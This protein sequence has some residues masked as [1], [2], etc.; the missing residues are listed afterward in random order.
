MSDRA[1]RDLL[2]VRPLAE[3]GHA[4][5]AAL[6]VWLAA[7]HLPASQLIVW[8]TVVLS[9]QVG[10]LILR[11]S[12][13]GRGA[14]GPTAL[15]PL[16]VSV[17]LLGLAWGG[18][19]WPLWS[20]L[21][22]DHFALTILM[23]CMLAG[24]W[25]LVFAADT[26]SVYLFTIPLLLPIAP[27]VLVHG[28]DDEHVAI[29]AMVLAYAGVTLAF[30]RRLHQ[31]LADRRRAEAALRDTEDQFQRFFEESPI[32][33]SITAPDGKLLRVNRA[34]GALFGY[35]VEELQL[36]SWVDLTH[37]DDL[38][39][40]H[41][42]VRALVAREADTRAMEARYRAK[43]G[44]W[45]WARL[46]M[47][48]HRGRDGQVL[49]FLTH[50]EDISDRKAAADRLSERD[51]QLGAAQAIAHV[52][53]WEWDIPTDRVTW[54][55]ELYRLHG[56]PPTSAASYRAFVAIVDPEDRER[57]ERVIAEGL[58][59]RRTVEYE[60]RIVRPDGVV[61]H[62]LGTNVVVLDRAGAP[63]GLTGT[64]L[65]ITDR[66]RADQALADSERYHRALIDQALDIITIIDADAVMRY[67]SPSVERVLGYRPEE[68]VGQRAFELIH[69][70][71]LEA[72]LKIFMEGVATPGALRTLEYRFRHKDG[73]W[74]HLE[75]V[76]RNL[77]DDPLIH[78]VVVN[79]RDA[80]ERK[81]ATE[82]LADRER[83]YRALIEQALDITTVVDADAFI[84][85]ASPSNER[86][87]GYT[88]AELVGQ[89]VFDFV[90]P[91]DLDTALSVFT[92]G[93]TA[94]GAI[95][96][97]E[98]RFRHRDGSWR[99]L[100]AVGRNLFDDPVIHAGIVNARDVTEQKRAEEAQQALLHE[101]QTAL[102]E[103]KT[104][105]GMIKVCAHCR[106]VLT[107][108]GGWEQFESYVRGHSDV[109]FSHGICPEC[110]AKWSAEL[111]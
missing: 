111:A 81:R 7:G 52:G 51:R 61:R 28:V 6:I 16:R 35:S 70:D 74:R 96:R 1:A 41:E 75:G 57:V 103:V 9:I 54:S 8:A 87:L 95:R 18:A 60:Y 38:A 32:G 72:V 108:E 56:L 65:D 45:V 88:P 47:A 86:V 85:Y 102:V 53:S 15:R 98:F 46:T 93:S 64:T 99:V 2:D 22:F 109:E 11:R 101:L 58:A 62:M 82:A 4:A 106:R 83:Y 59:E 110:A 90:H 78:A 34:Y 10:R 79:V 91:D 24:A 20:A 49:Y 23:Y 71:D 69:P 50:V 12:I 13:L 14:T 30:H 36:R 100:S 89:R 3:L 21:P 44:R 92:E 33:T 19:V 48:V 76:G 66:K 55:D 25:V 104:L 42:C 80:T 27:A 105:R 40:S 5:G 26:T 107:D 63:T 39:Q 97:L 94:A 37:P 67:L 84:R 77:L 17:L 68:L 43:D 29:A 73:S 31:T